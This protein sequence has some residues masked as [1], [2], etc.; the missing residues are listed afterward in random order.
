[1]ATNTGHKQPPWRRYMW[2]VGIYALSVVVVLG[3][4]YGLKAVFSGLFG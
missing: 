2:F 1:M 3:F 4:V